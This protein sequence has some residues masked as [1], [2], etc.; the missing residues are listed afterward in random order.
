[1]SEAGGA[2]QVRERKAPST[3]RRLAILA[4]AVAVLIAVLLV[5]IPESLRVVRGAALETSGR[6][7]LAVLA[8]ALVLWIG[9]ALPFHLTGLI[10]M[11]LLALI[12]VSPWGDLVKTGFG[13]E[14]TVFFIGVLALAS[15]LGRS[16]L[17]GRLGRLVLRFAGGSTRALVFGFLA[18]GAF[19][20]MWV[21]ALAAAALMLPLARGILRDEGEEPG[22]RFGTALMLAVAFG[23]LVGACGTPSGSGSNPVA[24]RFLA[25][26]GNFHLSYLDWM[27]IGVPVVIV[28]LPLA[29]GAILLLFPPERARLRNHASRLPEGIPRP[30][31]KAAPGGTEAIIAKSE[32]GALDTLGAIIS[33]GHDSREREASIPLS[34]DEKATGLVFLL[35]VATW[36]AAPFLEKLIATKISLALV[37]ALGAAA[38]FLPGIT[39]FRW[40]ELEKDM[41]WAGIL[42]I[43]TGIALGTALYK[44]GAAAWAAALVLGGIGGLSPFWRIAAVVVGVLVVKVVFSSNTLT[45]TIIVPLV[46]AL[47]ATIGIDAR[48]PALAAALTANLA[49]ILVTTSPVNVLPW[50][51]GYFSIADMAKTG[52]VFAPFAALALAAI[53]SLLGP[54]LLG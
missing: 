41:D 25:E 12:G 14:A 26:I 52:L 20:A 1:V 40:K 33:A 5:Q 30:F 46:L 8:F 29:W 2:N 49:V 38:L 31:S 3:P 7:A 22:S 43:A 11:A 42:L 45:G 21:T 23:P 54:G 34:R 9:E 4:I 44:S 53:L 10:A 50:S 28:L 39:S 24:L 35:V 19:L 37:A 36:L 48:L 51:T 6:H 17:A 16:G 13:D 27:R 47:G 18:A 15:A 32:P